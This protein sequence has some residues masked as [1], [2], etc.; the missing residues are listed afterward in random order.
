MGC[1]LRSAFCASCG[2]QW[3][4]CESGLMCTITAISVQCLQYNK[5]CTRYFMHFGMF[6]THLYIQ[7][8][9]VNRDALSSEPCSPGWLRKTIVASLLSV[10]TVDIVDYISSV[11]FCSCCVPLSNKRELETMAS[12]ASI[13][14][15]SALLPPTINFT[16]LFF[17]NLDLCLLCFC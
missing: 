6:V 3:T 2:C 10:T 17:A 1:L 15:L 16:R 5:V 13:L 14:Y 4:L 8:N 7:L 12:H 9:H 11:I